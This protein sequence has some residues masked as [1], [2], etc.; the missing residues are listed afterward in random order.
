[1]SDLQINVTESPKGT[2]VRLIGEASAANVPKLEPVLTQ[3]SAKKPKLVVIEG[4]EMSFISSLALGALLTFQKGVRRHGGEV[5]LAALQPM[6][7][8]MLQ[9][10]QLD[11]VFATYIDTEDALA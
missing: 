5:R 2:V 7:L 1:M 10:A 6:V 3:L 4:S 9:A 8:D 11:K